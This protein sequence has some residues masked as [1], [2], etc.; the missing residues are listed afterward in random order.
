MS[1]IVPIEV[2]T[3]RI[4]EIRGHK[5]MIDADLAALYEVP[6]KAL[7]QAVKRNPARFPNDFMFQLTSIERD[8]LVTKCDRLTKLKHSSAMPYVFTESG[9]AMLSSVLNSERAVLIN[10]EIVRAFIRLRQMLKDHDTLR[11]AIEGLERRVDSSE[12]NIHLALNLLQQVLFPPEQPVPKKTQPMGF[13]PPEKKEAK[14]LRS[15]S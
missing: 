13:T 9:V 4:F 11:F 6:T 15:D 12:R 5:V 8:E 14:R 10:V 7:N 2:I 3:N 1:D